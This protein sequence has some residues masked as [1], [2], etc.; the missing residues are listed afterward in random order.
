M[1]F[2]ICTFHTKLKIHKIEQIVLE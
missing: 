1:S 2:S